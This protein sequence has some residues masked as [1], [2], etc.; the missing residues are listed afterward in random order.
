MLRRSDLPKKGRG[1]I[2]LA[3]P[4]SREGTAWTGH[5]TAWQS[6]VLGVTGCIA[7]AGIAHLSHRSVFSADV[8]G[9]MH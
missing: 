1:R 8:H 9:Q 4:A 2:D 5:W 3:A 6:S 7:R